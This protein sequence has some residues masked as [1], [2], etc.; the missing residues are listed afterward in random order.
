MTAVVLLGQLGIFWRTDQANRDINR[1]FLTSYEVIINKVGDGDAATWEV[2]P[3][4]EN[5]GNTSAVKIRSRFLRDYYSPIWQMRRVNIAGG[6]DPDLS[7]ME[8]EGLP[9][10]SLSLAPHSKVSL[11]TLVI[12]DRA[13]EMIRLKTLSAFLFGEAE[14]FDVFDNWHRT[15]FCYRMIGSTV[16]VDDDYIGETSNI[17][18]FHVFVPD[19]LEIVRNYVGYRLC[20]RNNCI[21]DQCTNNRN[22][23]TVDYPSVKIIETYPTPRQTHD[24]RALMRLQRG[25]PPQP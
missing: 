23:P 15:K 3:F 13:R 18:N 8:F 1:A 4:L 16:G 5:A 7:E 2:S 10:A 24:P 21:D 17:G 11:G 20:R 12:T 25:V 22:R 14:Y 19:R 9:D 6:V